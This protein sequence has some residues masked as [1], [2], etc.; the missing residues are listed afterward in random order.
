MGAR[1]HLQKHQFL[2]TETD[3]TVEALVSDYLGNSDK[4][5]QGNTDKWSLMRMALIIKLA[6]TISVAVII[7]NKLSLLLPITEAAH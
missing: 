6:L 3:N 7:L 2:T 5:L 4:W 1:V